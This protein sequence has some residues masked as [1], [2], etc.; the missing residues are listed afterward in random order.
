MGRQ[1]TG[2]EGWR[3]NGV[4]VLMVLESGW[5]RPSASNAR[6][7]SEVGGALSDDR[8]G[9]ECDKIT[10]RAGF[11]R[12]VRVKRPFCRP[13]NRHE[14]GA[15]MS[16]FPS[17]WQTCACALLLST[18]QQRPALQPTSTADSVQKETVNRSCKKRI[19]KQADQSRTMPTR[20]PP[21]TSHSAALATARAI[22]DYAIARRNAQAMF[23]GAR[24]RCRWW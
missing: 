14:C 10:G 2:R 4:T 1:R 19:R 3:E 13:K 9:Y 21:P 11:L 15:V 12:S 24:T 17:R 23:E 6:R 22:I 7:R 8:R 20:L 18:L 5:S 16:P